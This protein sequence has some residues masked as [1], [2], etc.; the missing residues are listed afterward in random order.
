MERGQLACV[1]SGWHPGHSPAE[2]GRDG[3]SCTCTPFLSDNLGSHGCVQDLGNT[4][5]SI[6]LSRSAFDRNETGK[7]VLRAVRSLGVDANLNDRNDICIGKN[8][9]G[10]LLISLYVWAG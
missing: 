10:L 9:I 8:K 3:V 1:P 2:R 4:N 7:L 5:F 6:H